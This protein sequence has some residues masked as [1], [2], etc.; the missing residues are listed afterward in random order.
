MQKSGIISMESLFEIKAPLASFDTVDLG[1]DEEKTDPTVELMPVTPEE[2]IAESVDSASS[3]NSQSAECKLKYEKSLAKVETLSTVETP[4]VSSFN[5]GSTEAHTFED[6]TEK[7]ENTGTTGSTETNSSENNAAGG[8]IL[9]RLKQKSKKHKETE[10]KVKYQH[11]E[12]TSDLSDQEK[13]PVPE[14]KLASQFRIYDSDTDSSDS[15]SGYI[16]SGFISALKGVKKGSKT[17][18]K[19]AVKT[20]DRYNLS[21][22]DTTPNASPRVFRPVLPPPL[23][24]EERAQQSKRKA[25]EKRLQRLQVT[26][27]PIERP[28][29]TTPID[30]FGLDEYAVISSPEKTP[31]SGNL[32]KLKITL[33][34]DEFNQKLRS[35][36]KSRITETHEPHAFSFNE[37][38]LFT[39]TKSALVVQ[40][41]GAKGL[42]P[43][44]ILIPPTL[45]PALSPRSK[46]CSTALNLSPRSPRYLYTPHQSKTAVVSPS[47]VGANWAKF[48]DEKP[49]KK[50]DSSLKELVK[51]EPFCNTSDLIENVSADNSDLI[52]KDKVLNEEEILTVNVK[53]VDE[54]KVCDITC[55]S[56]AINKENKVKN[57]VNENQ[58]KDTNITSGDSQTNTLS[59]IDSNHEDKKPVLN[60]FRK[61]ETNAINTTKT[62]E[63]DAW[64]L[65]NSAFDNRF[66]ADVEL[67]TESNI[68]ETLKEII[69]NAFK[70]ESFKLELEGN[71][72]ICDTLTNQNE[73]EKTIDNFSSQS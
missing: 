36:R 42:S 10:S 53:V 30:I 23:T 28:R 44:K 19:K 71:D 31:Q 72:N 41:D 4:S 8:D 49:N 2:S 51:D 7:C 1:D 40:D 17:K 29:S 35:P 18:S 25:Y 56:V 55:E 12:N 66:E 37:D 68:G 65:H 27:S 58:K 46:R 22:S 73:V 39:H 57:S 34:P 24:E 15:D 61:N 64:V 50:P 38:L 13:S 70:E 45:S 14:L 47:H 16:R 21:G 67:S 3:A 54:K 9:H 6:E 59:V 32:E 52:A 62:I 11:I 60:N 48:E 63:D 26:T 5:V 20:I 69:D 33:P 43:K